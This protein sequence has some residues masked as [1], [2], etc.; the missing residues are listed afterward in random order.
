VTYEPDGKSFVALVEGECHVA[1]H[2]S[3]IFATDEKTRTVTREFT[4]A[5][6][7][8]NTS[9]WTSMIHCATDG[10][11]RLVTYPF[12]TANLLCYSPTDDTWTFAACG[13]PPKDKCAEACFAMMD[14]LYTTRNCGRY[15]LVSYYDTVRRKLSAVVFDFVYRRWVAIPPL[16][17]MS[18]ESF[19]ALHPATPN[20]TSLV[21]CATSPDLPISIARIRIVDGGCESDWTWH[22]LD[23]WYDC[24]GGCAAPDPGAVSD[25]DR[26]EPHQHRFPYTSAIVDLHLGRFYL[27]GARRG[28][29]NDSL[30]TSIQWSPDESPWHRLVTWDVREWCEVKEAPSWNH[31]RR[32][33]QRLLGMWKPP[34]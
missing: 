25:G 21:I 29:E 32:I 19:D 30:R 20:S 2:E 6:G 9:R 1:M 24:D 23:M 13:I 4:P 7:G 5:R 15:S 8:C 3:V 12:I 10:R 26:D 34:P 17:K 22:V 18:V 33:F 11:L 16:K 28:M 27:L 14:K 31:P